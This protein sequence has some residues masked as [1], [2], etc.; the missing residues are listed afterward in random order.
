MNTAKARKRR[1]TLW[2]KS[3]GRCWY[4]GNEIPIEKQSLDHL[5][6]LSRGGHRWRQDNLVAS[7]LNC[8]S[9]KGDL[10]LEEFRVLREKS[11]R[12]LPRRHPNREGP[13]RF[14]FEREGWAPALVL[15]GCCGQELGEAV[16]T[17][18]YNPDRHCW[19]VVRICRGCADPADLLLDRLLRDELARQAV[20]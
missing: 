20:R 5:T 4:C 16:T 1:E 2:R 6:P 18:V 10:T 15:C 12:Y 13:Y 14:A 9:H 3:A 19:E 8:N 7:C 17:E 11:R